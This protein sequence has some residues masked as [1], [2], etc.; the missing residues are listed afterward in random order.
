M[1][2]LKKQI[3][4]KITETELQ[5]RQKNLEKFKQII[6]IFRPSGHKLL[7]SEK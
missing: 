7:Y 3:E 5:T 2:W 4:E 6:D 1:E